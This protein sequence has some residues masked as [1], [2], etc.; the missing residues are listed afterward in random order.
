MWNK[1]KAALK[2][3]KNA[4]IKAFRW[5]TGTAA[6][7]VGYG[8]MGISTVVAFIAAFRVAVILMLANAVIWGG[9]ALVD[10]G[11]II[12]GVPVQIGNTYDQYMYDEE[13]EAQYIH[14][15]KL[16]K[17]HKQLEL[18]EVNRRIAS[19]KR[20][21]LNENLRDAKKTVKDIR[22]LPWISD[23]LRESANETLDYISRTVK[24]EDEIEVPENLNHHVHDVGIVKYSDGKVFIEESEAQKKEPVQ[25]PF[26]ADIRKALAEKGIEAKDTDF[27]P[28][29]GSTGYLDQYDANDLAPWTFGRDS[30][31]R[32]YV[33][34]PWISEARPD[35][36]M[37]Y[38][39]VVI[40]Q[41]YPSSGIIVQ[42]HLDGYNVDIG[43][44]DND[45]FLA[46]IANGEH[47]FGDMTLAFVDKAPDLDRFGKAV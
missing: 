35:M 10:I 12:S 43:L 15:K 45:S 38:G 31:G 39:R 7:V 6:K 36:D 16:D 27:Q 26:F 34:T 24:E 33:V 2:A 46:M 4:V 23:S 25:A 41:R 19:L 47:T 5:V 22:D 42:G 30:E 21:K 8:V 44:C 29:I 28:A 14:R 40:F 13:E 37:R 3:A 32:E 11:D 20:E 1:V 17:A 9:A 18:E